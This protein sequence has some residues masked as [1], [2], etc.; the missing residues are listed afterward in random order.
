MLSPTSPF[1]AVLIGGPPHSGKSVL[2]YSLS[3]ALRQ[4]DIPHYVLRACPDGEGD[5]SNQADQSLVRTIRLKGKFNEVY[6][7]RIARYLA[8]RHLPLL[9][10][11]GGRPTETQQALFGLCT[12]AILLAAAN[13][14]D[15]YV[16]E[17]AE[18]QKMLLQQQVTPLAYLESLLP[19]EDRLDE[20]GPPLIGAIANLQRGETAV[21]PVITALVTQLRS[22]FAYNEAELARIHLAHAP[23]ELALD[24]P[25]LARTLGAADAIWRPEQLPAL[26][27]YLPAGAPLALYGRS[28]NWISVAL[29]LLAHPAPIWLYDARLGWVQP[30]TLP[31]T[32]TN[33]QT[34]PGWSA[35]LHEQDGFLSLEMATTGQE[36]DIDEPEGLPL[37]SIPDGQ[38]LVLSGKIPHWLTT[39]VARQFSLTATW[40]AL[41]QP[42]LAGAVVVD[43]RETA[44]AVGQIIPFTPISV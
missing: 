7:A 15:I 21:G 20:G 31:V 27:D 8:N 2:V 4:A 5:W 39:A 25:A 34:Q 18:W 22:L 19:G 10:D 6:V 29:S 44:V 24:L 42:H 38:G 33:S 40:T 3:R 9:V 26:L 41:Y 17:M 43:S 37:P 35:A 32:N 28:P 12:H 16:R 30:P 36:L 14:P 1:P 23:V 11:V 13:D